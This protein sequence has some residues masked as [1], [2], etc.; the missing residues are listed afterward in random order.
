[1]KNK[2]PKDIIDNAIR[3]GKFKG[4]GVLKSIVVNGKEIKVDE[5]KELK[6]N[7]NRK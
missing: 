5:H 4:F 1:M 2:T 3:D 6:I 7:K